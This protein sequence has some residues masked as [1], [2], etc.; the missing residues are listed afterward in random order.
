MAW[1]RPYR[2]GTLQTRMMRGLRFAAASE[3]E[4]TVGQPI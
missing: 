4:A 2:F 1:D 3:R